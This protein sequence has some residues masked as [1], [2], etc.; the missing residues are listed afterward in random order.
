M[1]EYGLGIEVDGRANYEDM[2]GTC[3]TWEELGILCFLSCTSWSSFQ[4]VGIRLVRWGGYLLWCWACI[5]I[6][7]LLM[8]GIIF[9]RL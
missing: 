5:S 6:C 4:R 8:A 1:F 3:C 9:F 7:R 2:K